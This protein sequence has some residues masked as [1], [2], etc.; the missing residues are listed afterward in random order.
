MKKLN[1]VI[2][3]SLCAGILC[4]GIKVGSEMFDATKSTITKDGFLHEPTFFLLPLGWIFIIGGM[5]LLGFKFIM[6][7]RHYPA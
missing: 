7:L 4:F 5:L 3:S 2:I 6:K 1:Y